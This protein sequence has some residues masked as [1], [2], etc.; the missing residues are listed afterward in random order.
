MKTSFRKMSLIF[1][2]CAF[3]GLIVSC[4]QN[5][6]HS[7][8]KK[9]K[10][11]KKHK[12]ADNHSG[13]HVKISA[14]AKKRF[15]IR[16]GKAKKG[17]LAKRISVPAEIKHVPDQVSEVGPL[18]RGQVEKLNVEV[19]DEVQKG[20]TL[21]VMRSIQLGRVRAKVQKAKSSFEVAK[22]NFERVERLKKKGIVSEE[23][24]LSRKRAYKEAKAE[25]KGAKS[26]L[27]AFNVSTGSG[28][29]YHIKTDISGEVIKQDASVGEVKRPGEPLFVVV[30]D[31]KVW[32]VGHAFERDLGR[33]QKGQKA[34]L[35]FDG[36]S[37]RQWEGKV[38]WIS[39]VVDR[40]TRNVKLRVVLGNKNRHLRAGMY[41]TIHLR[42]KST[43]SSDAIVP[44][45]AVQKIGHKRFVF[46]PEGDRKYKARRVVLGEERGG[47][48]TIKSGIQP[49][50][51][52]V[53][54]GAF[55][56]KATMTAASRA[57]GHHH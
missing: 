2:C 15:G 7:G 3:A 10:K 37:K 25:L 50:D 21:A 18:V 43:N 28:S 12:K 14:K 22:T 41:G 29:R 57:G 34:L 26:E 5:D 9:H 4:S 46:T 32:V 30:N 44:I 31:S 36:Y 38:A 19:G 48:V 52:Y 56:L 33:I 8:S 54:K 11:H 45:D 53:R 51:E 23:R 27:S 40:D 49:G 47:L 42:S 17:S 6:A 39:R 35:S 16:T 20:E 13:K 24:Y 55:D 1:L